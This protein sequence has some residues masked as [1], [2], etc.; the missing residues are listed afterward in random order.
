MASG[1]RST[2][3]TKPTAAGSISAI[4]PLLNSLFGFSSQTGKGSG[5][6]EL[7]GG[8][9]FG[10][11]GSAPRYTWQPTPGVTGGGAGGTGRGF[12]GPGGGRPGF[13][14]APSAGGYTPVP[15]PGTGAPA[16]LSPERFGVL[17][18][19]LDI[20]NPGA[21]GAAALLP[22]L[23]GGAA[24]GLGLLGDT[25]SAYREGVGTGF[26]TDLSPIIAEETR[27]LYQDILPQIGQNF[28]AMNE[29]GPFS[30]DLTGQVV[31]AGR[32]L[33][34]QLGAL[35]FQADEAAAARRA[36]LLPL[37]TSI[38]SGMNEVP[39]RSAEN[40]LS[41]GQ[42]LILE[43]TP[44]GRAAT[45]L[46]LLSGQVPTGAVVRGN[47]G[48]SKGGGGGITFLSGGTSSTAGTGGG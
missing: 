35:Q 41:L 39:F 32:D 28:I 34:S 38:A 27:R 11:L 8:Q 42:Q 44:A 19:L 7:T 14:G 46:Q 9:S 37:G 30:T 20:Q 26:R 31:G 3:E 47:R 33:A 5:L 22:A 6:F 1:S 40:L 12:G 29:A 48:E 2:S 45:A 21:P 25:A 10:G 16:P 18:D 15:V 4:T 24:A 17:G 13:G 23:E 36:G 43:G